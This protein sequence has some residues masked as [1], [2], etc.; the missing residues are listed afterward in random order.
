MS[1]RSYTQL[2]KLGL[3]NFELF[4]DTGSRGTT[5][6]EKSLK[7]SYF[8]DMH[9]INHY[10]YTTESSEDPED[11]DSGALSFAFL[12]PKTRIV[13]L[14]EALEEKHPGRYNYDFMNC[15]DKKEYFTS[16][17]LSMDTYII[18][19]KLCE[20]TKNITPK[21][22][23]ELWYGNIEDRMPK[24]RT[25]YSVVAQICNRLFRRTNED[26]THFTQVRRRIDIVKKAL[27]YPKMF[28]DL[29]GGVEEI[30]DAVK[31]ARLHGSK[32]LENI[33]EKRMEVITENYQR[34]GRLWATEQ[35][36]I[37]T[38]L[39]QGLERITH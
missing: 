17:S 19:P 14:F 8:D 33:V 1:V 22:S 38:E 12:A 3:Y 2:L 35:L 27:S 24:A 29:P 16:G 25:L 20:F 11:V 6:I 23:K 4:R 37:L 9:E 7:G 21:L 5:A 30:L 10:L 31:F 28:Y 32:E 26:N 18:K 15:A 34:L 39:E 36:D 13:Q